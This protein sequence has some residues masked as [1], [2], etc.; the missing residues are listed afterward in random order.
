MSRMSAEELENLFELF[1]NGASFQ[2][3]AGECWESSHK[4]KVSTAKWAFQKAAELNEQAADIL[5]EIRSP[6][7]D[8]FLEDTAADNDQNDR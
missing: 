8:R 1:H 4:T 7:L 2:R 3:A 6:L 5:E